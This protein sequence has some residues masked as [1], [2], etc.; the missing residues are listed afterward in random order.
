MHIYQQEELATETDEQRHVQLQ[1]DR[2]RHQ[3]QRLAQATT[4]LLDQP[5]VQAKMR[6]FHTALNSLEVYMLGSIP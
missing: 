3:Q 5:A 1:I 2:E 4:P 6:K